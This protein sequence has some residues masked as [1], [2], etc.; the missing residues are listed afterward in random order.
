MN[1][2][3]QKNNS[4]PVK[5][6]IIS[7]LVVFI[8][9]LWQGNKGFS[10]WD[11]GFLWYGVQRVLLGEV[12]I[13][14]FMAYDPGR[15]YWSSI[16]LSVIG[17]NGIMSLR[18]T[19]AIFQAL[20]LFVGLWLI[21]SSAN[22][23][24]NY[25]ALFGIISTV[26]LAVWMFPRHK[27]F[28]ISISIFL[29]GALTYIAS[30]PIPKRYVIAGICVGLV[31]V[32]GR[33]HGMYGAAASLGLMCWLQIK[34]RSAPGFLNG[35][36]L[37]GMGVVIG[38]LPIVFMALMIPGFAV[39]LW[40]SIRFL[41]EYK[42][43][44]L[45]L[46]VPW[47]WTVSLT[48][49]SIGDVAR[50]ILIGF[51][52]IGT[53]LFGMFSVIWVVSQ[54]LKEKPVPPSL[55]ASAFLAIPYAHYAFSRPDI[56]HLAQSIFPLLVGCLVILSSSRA[57]IKW[58]LAVALCTASFW[59]MHVFHPGWQCVASKQCVSIEISGRQLK[60][61][62][63]TANEITLLRQLSGQFTPNGQAF[64]ATPFWPGAYA[65]LERRSP[66]W[67][68]YALFSR[69]EAFENREIERIKASNPGFVFVLDLPLDGREELRFKNTHPLTYRFI[70]ENF[71]PIKVLQNP[72]YQ[73]F[74]ARGER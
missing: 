40:E 16:L 36:V 31:A 67:E 20:G 44:N 28:D 58:P 74:K 69:S 34:N 42:A 65:L 10:L 57:S 52:F 24:A 64:I 47:P 27:L 35:I 30:N 22:R 33:N 72:A 2:V 45:S 66:M 19:V 56:G 39:A 14:D 63:G 12:P 6:L 1:Q 46:S 53:V 25:S 55:V 71:E 3:T 38:F 61:D 68:I 4:I 54:R 5:T 26:T 43:T 37:W 17:D 60:V 21:T 32:F 62:P 48:A 51:F 15:Y 7:C 9:F 50:G 29:I 18:A 49:A 59:V 11:E 41:F 23:E 70:L 13:R 8:S 73:I